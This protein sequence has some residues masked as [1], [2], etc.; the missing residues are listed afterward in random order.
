MAPPTPQERHLVSSLFQNCG[1]A[2]LWNLL[3]KISAAAVAT[4][5]RLGCSGGGRAL[6]HQGSVSPSCLCIPEQAGSG[7]I[8]ASFACPA[9]LGRPLEPKVGPWESPLESMQP[10]MSARVG[11]RGENAPGRIWEFCSFLP[12][13]PSSQGLHYSSVLEVN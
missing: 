8:R 9:F 5:R 10:T 1:Q 3:Y 12:L 11:E 6:L 13:Y 4:L 7:P 2:L